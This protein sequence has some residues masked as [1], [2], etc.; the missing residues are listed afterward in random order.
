MAPATTHYMPP[1]PSGSTTAAPSTSGEHQV[2]HLCHFSMS[3]ITEL[4]ELAGRHVHVVDIASQLLHVHSL[5][6]S[7]HVAW[8][9]HSKLAL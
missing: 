3:S 1:N 5:A 2:S 6:A 7:T 9:V 4:A 8:L